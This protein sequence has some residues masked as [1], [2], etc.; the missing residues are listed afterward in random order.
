MNTFAYTYKVSSFLE[1]KSKMNVNCDIYVSSCQCWLLKFML[2]FMK[3]F[4]FLLTLLVIKCALRLVWADIYFLCKG[5]LDWHK[6]GFMV[7]RSAVSP[8]KHIFHEKKYSNPRQ[9]RVLNWK[10]RFI[11]LQ[12]NQKLPMS[13][14]TS[15]WGHNFD[16]G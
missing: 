16:Q 7:L 10:S 5:Y 1:A 2:K 15:C 14:M 3:V 9:V 13:I 8:H 4:F 11:L 12:I 6:A